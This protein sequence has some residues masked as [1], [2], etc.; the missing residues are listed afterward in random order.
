MQGAVRQ[1]PARLSAYGFQV[2][3]N[4]TKSS[5]MIVPASTVLPVFTSMLLKFGCALPSLDKPL[6]SANR[7]RQ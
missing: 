6:S 1:P 7:T 3:V 5:L 4:C 2:T